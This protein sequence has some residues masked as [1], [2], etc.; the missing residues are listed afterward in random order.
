[1]ANSLYDLQWGHVYSDVETDGRRRLQEQQPRL[2]NG[3]T[4]IRTWK[5]EVATRWQTLSMI[6][7]GATS[8]RTWKLSIM[9][10]V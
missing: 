8:I 6:F 3:A 10:T 5:L 7:N 4:S 9:C 2:F 1:M